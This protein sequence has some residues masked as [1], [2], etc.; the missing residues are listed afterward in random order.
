M[1][2]IYV[3]IKVSLAGIIFLSI[4]ICHGFLFMNNRICVTNVGH[5]FCACYLLP[6]LHIQSLNPWALGKETEKIKSWVILSVLMELSEVTLPVYSLELKALHTNHVACLPEPPPPWPIFREIQKR[7]VFLW[8]AGCASLAW[9]TLSTQIGSL[10]LRPV[11]Y[12]SNYVV[13]R[14]VDYLV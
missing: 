10:Y 14:W 7:D 5:V 13:K 9:D 6:F 12:I 11:I 8:G 4:L 3:T 2:I 1:H